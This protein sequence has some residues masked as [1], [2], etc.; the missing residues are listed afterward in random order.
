VLE[1]FFRDAEASGGE[2]SGLEAV[3]NIDWVR[4]GRE[5]LRACFKGWF[6][7]ARRL[8]EEAKVGQLL[9]EAE[10]DFVEAAQR[11]FSKL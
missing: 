5:A 4:Q 7:Q 6:G 2:G 11:K 9:T 3:G 1:D 8:R 10:R